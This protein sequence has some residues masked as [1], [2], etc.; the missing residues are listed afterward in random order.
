MTSSVNGRE[1]GRDR[2]SSA[3]WS[4]EELVSYASWNSRVEQGGLIGSG[5][6]Q[7]GCLYEL[8]NR[9]GADGFPWLAAGDEVRLAIEGMGEI[10]AAVLSPENDA[11]PGL[12]DVA[13]VDEDQPATPS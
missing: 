6:C 13:P 7:G 8:R 11:W 2:W 1:Y 3:N 9:H 12:R 5:T 10:C 4:F